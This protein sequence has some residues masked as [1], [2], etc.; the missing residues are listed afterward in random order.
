MGNN[1]SPNAAQSLLLAQRL[2]QAEDEKRFLRRRRRA[3]EQ[4][5]A[6]LKRTMNSGSPEGGTREKYPAT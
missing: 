3:L 5:L 6:V 4:E 1:K 2:M